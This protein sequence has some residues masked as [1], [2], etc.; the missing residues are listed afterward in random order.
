MT[1][2]IT[3]VL[4]ERAERAG[5]PVLDLDRIAADGEHRA[6]RARVT[7][8]AGASGVGLLAA[9][10]VGAVVLAGLDGSPGRSAT[11]PDVAGA[12][13]SAP[14]APVPVS[15]MLSY[16][17]GESIVVPQADL[18][19][20][21]GKRV[22]SFVPVD[23]GFVWMAPEGAVSFLPSDGGASTTI[24]LTEPSGGALRAE[25]DGSLVAWI[26]FAVTGGP[27]LVVHDTATGAEVLRTGENLDADADA[28]RDSPN[29]AYVYAVDRG[30]V[31]WRNSAGA[32]R[33]EVATGRS[34]VLDPDAG[35]FRIGDVAAGQI[36]S[37]ASTGEGDARDDSATRVGPGLSGGTVLPWSGNDHLSPD[38]RSMSFEDEDELVVVDVATGREVGPENPGYDYWV[39]TQWVGSD[40]VAVLGIRDIAALDNPDGPDTAPLEFLTCEIPDGACTVVAEDEIDL[41]AFAIPVGETS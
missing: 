41:N 1:S 38:A 26:D 33:T 31:Y 34:E 28:Y 7:R 35:G 9:A 6:R 8:I 2:L 30:S 32:V 21:A 22:A 10:T 19:L 24:G 14:A 12:P 13:S 11:G 40:T 3:D 27:E 20:R 5:S 25:N 17:T 18:E 29:P 15:R 36:A 16:A 4:T 39:V 37:T 23:D